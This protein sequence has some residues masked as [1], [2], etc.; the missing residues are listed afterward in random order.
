MNNII[1]WVVDSELDGWVNKDFQELEDN[2][3]S[4]DGDMENENNSGD[5]EIDNWTKELNKNFS[6]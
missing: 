1:N 3:F 5:T 6:N 4:S 2:N